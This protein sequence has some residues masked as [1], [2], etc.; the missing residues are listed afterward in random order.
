MGEPRAKKLSIPKL[1]GNSAFRLVDPQSY[2]FLVP[3]ILLLII[4]LP[5]LSLPY[6]WDEAWSYMVAIDKM[7]EVGPSLFPGAVPIDICKG[8]PQFFY[9]AAAFWMNLFPGKILYMRILPLLISVAVLVFV[10]YGLKRL[11]SLQ[12]ANV[13]VILLGVQSM[14]LAQSILVLPEM[15]LSLWLVISFFSF[16]R[17]NF[18]T[19]AVAGSL[20]ILT[21]E[22]ALVFV[23]IFLL[24]YLLFSIK[25]NGGNRFAAKSFLW[26]I[27]PILVYSAFLIL[28]KA[29]FGVFFFQ[30]HLGYISYDFA[31]ISKK[32]GSAFTIAFIHYGRIMIFAA[33]AIFFVVLIAKR[34]NVKNRNALLCLAL[35]IFAYLLFLGINFYSPRYTLSLVVLLILAFSILFDQLPVSWIFK[36]SFALIVSSICLFYSLN[37]KRNIDIDLGYVEVIEVNREMVKYCEDNNFYNEPIA[38]SF[39]MNYCLKN[40]VTGYLKGP[41]VFRQVGGFNQYKNAKYFIY[42][43]TSDKDPVIELV[44]SDFKLVKAFA[45]KHAWGYIYENTA[46]EPSR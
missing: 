5:H 36:M 37:S 44:R 18:K 22:T 11:T 7:A 29:K 12:T 23:V 14:F 25:R 8:H 34:A 4:Q 33:I 39:N 15:M 13:G 21:K 42:E 3:V 10:F 19:Y 28:H 26:V 35:L 41:E 40:K 24:C 45:N 38:A 46:P 17:Q 2:V 30:E 32:I 9:F 6:F 20:M 16:V 43:S 27:T 1:M 31:A